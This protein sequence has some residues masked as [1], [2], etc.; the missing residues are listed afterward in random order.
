MHFSGGTVTQHVLLCPWAYLRARRSGQTQKC[1]HGV[2]L[3]GVKEGLVV[4]RSRKKHKQRGLRPINQKIRLSWSWTLI[5]W[6]SLWACAAWGNNLGGCE[7]Q[8]RLVV[9]SVQGQTSAVSVIGGH[10]LL[11]MQRRVN[12]L[13]RSARLGFSRLAHSWS[14]A[15]S[16]TLCLLPLSPP[17]HKTDISK[18]LYSCEHPCRLCLWHSIQPMLQVHLHFEPPISS[19]GWCHS[20]RMLK[21]P[22]VYKGSKRT[23]ANTV[24]Q[25]C[26]VFGRVCLISTAA[27]LIPE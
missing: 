2:F 12:K 9:L 1:V 4:L 13:T 15:P 21:A 10:C 18:E 23:S 20:A 16:L 19:T 7:K 26:V 17:G 22:S 25:V 24:H 5:I 27:K 11:R 14:L 8:L 6:N 3:P